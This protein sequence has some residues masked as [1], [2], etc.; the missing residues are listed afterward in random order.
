MSVGTRF[1]IET[2][3]G[4]WALKLIRP[5]K[6]EVEVVGTDPR[7]AARPAPVLG[8]FVESCEPTTKVG[9]PGCIIKGQS[10]SVRFRDA[11][12]VSQP[13]KSVRIEGP[14]WSYEL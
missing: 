5:T 2:E 14:N 7:F 4:V 1:L 8:V 11:V 10:F 6:L 9:T 3:G 12:L 13:I